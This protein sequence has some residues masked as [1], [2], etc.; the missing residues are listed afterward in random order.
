MN[1][2]RRELQILVA[3]MAIVMAVWASAHP[4]AGAGLP[5]KGLK[6]VPYEARS[7]APRGAKTLACC[8]T[9]LERRKFLF[10]VYSV[11]RETKGTV[12]DET[13]LDVFEWGRGLRRLHHVL[14][15]N[16]PFGRA[17]H[18]P[19]PSLIW[20]MPTKM[21]CPM[22]VFSESNFLLLTIFPQGFAGPVQHVSW[23]TGESGSYWEQIGRAHV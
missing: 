4:A 3:W 13:W 7:V 18:P 12:T 14:L 17:E 6:P 10:H 20:L 22:I 5:L 8:T 11:H 2:W 19:V 1:P 23:I 16:Y 21:Q 15:E 9:N